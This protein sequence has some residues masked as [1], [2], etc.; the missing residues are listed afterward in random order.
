MPMGDRPD[1]YWPSAPCCKRE[2]QHSPPPFQCY[3]I[4]ALLISKEDKE[5]K[6][7][8]AQ[9]P[10]SQSPPG[11]VTTQSST[12]QSLGTLDNTAALQGTTDSQPLGDLATE[13]ALKTNS[14]ALHSPHSARPGQEH[15]WPDLVEPVDRRMERS[16]PRA[17]FLRK[18]A[19]CIYN[20]ELSAIGCVG[21]RRAPHSTSTGGLGLNRPGTTGCFTGPDSTEFGSKRLISVGEE[22]IRDSLFRKEG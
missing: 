11:G 5:E 12:G 9:N 19:Q 15:S 4:P 22:N 8:K 1:Y 6:E 20:S 10:Q 7:A 14:K 13:L 17:R 18:H 21:V 2:T 16:P 3:S